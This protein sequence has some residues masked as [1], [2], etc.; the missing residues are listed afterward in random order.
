MPFGQLPVLIIDGKHKL[1]QSGA[2]VRYLGRELN[3]EGE[4]LL[5]TAYV[6]M[7]TEA[8]CEMYS[9]LLFFEATET[10]KVCLEMLSIRHILFV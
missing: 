10:K 6:D 8:I 7:V 5:L 4:D 1:A 9:K 2:I 3:M